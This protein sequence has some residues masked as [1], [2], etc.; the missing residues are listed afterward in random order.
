MACLSSADNAEML[1]KLQEE[2]GPQDFAKVEVQLRKDVLA[3]T[4]IKV[5][6]LFT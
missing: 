1:A 4:D 2:V 3:S 5:V 6:M